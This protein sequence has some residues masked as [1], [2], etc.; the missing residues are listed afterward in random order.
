MTAPRAREQSDPPAPPDRRPPRRGGG[1][2]PSTYASSAG[3]G[4]RGLLRPARRTALAAA[5]LV[6]GSLALA[7]PAQAQSTTEI[8]SL[9]MTPGSISG[10]LVV[11]WD[12]V[13]GSLGSTIAE[14]TFSY[15]NKSYT[16]LLAQNV[17]QGGNN[18]LLIRVN[19]RFD[20]AALSDLILVVDSDEFPLADASIFTTTTGNDT[21]QWDNAGL[22][23]SAGTDVSLS[24]KAIT[25]R[26]TP[27]AFNVRGGGNKLWLFVNANLSNI[28]PPTSAFT[29]T[30][31]GSPVTIGSISL[32]TNLRT[33][34]LTDFSPL[35][36]AGQTVTLDYTDP[37]TGDDTNAIQDINGLD[38]ASFSNVVVNDSA[39]TLPKPTAAAVPADGATVAL[40]FSETLLIFQPAY[41]S[42]IRNAFTV[43]VDGTERQ[44]TDFAVSGAT[45]TLT[46]SDTIEGGQTVVVGYDRSAAGR[47][48]LGT[49]SK[50]LVA[51]FTTGE[52]S[53]PAVTNNSTA[54]PARLA[55]AAV[56]AAGTRLTL[57]FN[58]SLNAESSA[59][60]WFTVMADGAD[61][62]I[63]AFQGLSTASDSFTILFFSGSPIYKDEAVVVVYEKPAGSD[64][65]TDEANDVPVA[66]FTT[67]LDGVPAVANAATTVAP[68][69]PDTAASAS[70]VGTGGS[71]LVLA[72]DG[73]LATDNKPPASAFSITAGGV[74][75]GI[76]TVLLSSTMTEG[77]VSLAGLTPK[78]R[79]GETV[80]LT[81]TDPTSA[82]D[83]NALQGTTGTDV[84]SFTVT[85]TNAS[86]VTTG[87]PRP[88]TGLTATA[89][90]A[91]IVDLA[92]TAPA[93]DGDSAITGYKVEVSNT[94]SS[95]WTDLAAD[96]GDANAW[97]RHTGLS[98]G[99]T[100]YYRVSAINANGTSP[101][102][103]SA[104]A[105]TMTGALHAVPATIHGDEIWSAEL[106]VGRRANLA[107][108]DAENYDNT[109]GALSQATFDRGDGTMVTVSVV[110]Y[111]SRGR[112]FLW[113]LSTGLGA[114]FFNLHLGAATVE[115]D[116]PGNS[117]SLIVED[118]SNPGWS[119][120]DT[121]DVRLVEATAPAKPTGFTAT[122]AGNAQIDLA[123]TAPADDGGRA[124]S[125]YKIEVSDDGS[126]GSWDDLVADTASTDTAYS[127]TG[128]SA[129]DTRH[130]QVSA[131][132]AVGT[133]DAS[134]SDNATTQRTVPDPPEASAIADGTSKIV[135]SWSVPANDGGSAVTGYRLQVSPDGVSD[136]RN[137][138]NNTTD[139][140]YEHTGLSAGTT[141]HYRVYATNAQGTSQPSAVV[142][143]M[144]QGAGNTCTVNTAAGD[145][146]CGVVTVALHTEGGFD[147]AY[148]FVDTSVTTNTSD[149]GALSDE[150]FP[151]GP[152][153]YTIDVVTVGLD[154]VGGNLAFSLTSGLTAADKEKLVLHVGSR[155]FAFSDV[156]ANTDFTY[157]WHLS[158]L[159]WSSATSI[160]LR[161]RRVPAAPGAPTNLMAEAD[162]GTTIELSWTA[163]VDNGGSAITGYRIEVSDDGSTDWTDLEADT[164][165]A[166]TSYTHT[167][168]SPGDTR[169]YRVSAI[170][171]T[172]RSEASDSEDA[173]T[174]D[175]PTLSSATVN[176]V[177]TII[178]LRFSE[179]LDR[180]AGG[181][182]P[183]SA[184]SVSV[185][186]VSITVGDASIL[187]TSP[188]QV[189]LTSLGRTI[190][191]GQAVTVTYTD[192]T[193]GDDAAAIQDS[194]GDDTPSFTTGEDGVPAVVNNST[195]TPPVATPTNFRAMA[196]DAQVTLSWDEP[197]SDSGVT[198]H[199]Y[200]FR[201]D[202]D[203][204][205]WIEIDDSGPG[206]TNASGFTVTALENGTEYT[207]E[208]RAGGD[209][210]DSL[211]AD[212]VRVT[213]TGEAAPTIE[214]VA[215]TSTPR[216]TSAG[217][218]EPDTYGRGEP[219]E[220]S[221]TFSEAV[222]RTGDPQ[223]GFSLDGARVAD[224]ASGTGSETL[225]FVYSVRQDDVDDD[226]IWV[227][228]HS[229]GTRTLQLDSDDA[230]AAVEGGADA[231]LEH[232]R[233]NQL[234]G[235]KVDGSRVSEDV[236]EEPVRVTLHL[237]EAD[238]EVPE[239]GGA[240]TV[241]ARAS[242]GAGSAFTVT[243]SAQPVAPATAGD[244][245]LSTNPVLRFTANA[246]ASTGTV[247]IT[248]VDDDVPE[249]RDAVRV[250]GEVSGADIAD[251]EPVTL[252]IA[253]DDDLE[254][255]DVAVEGPAQVSE[256]DGAASV[257][258]TLTTQGTDRPASAAQLY[259]AVQ[260]GTATRGEDW[261]APSG[262]E[263]GTQSV[264]FATVPPG[265]F[266]ANGDGNWEARRS[267]TL[268]IV[269]DAEREASETVVFRVDTGSSRY[270]SAPHTI[271]IVDDDGPPGAPEKPA[272]AAV[273]GSFTSLEADWDEP[274]LDGA[275]A[276]TGYELQYREGA[277]GAWTAW[278]HEGASTTARLTGLAAETAYRV[279]V[280]ALNG[281][282]A[283]G[284]S[285]PSE[286]VLTGSYT[287]RGICN[288]TQRVEDRIMVR[289]KY[290]HSFK[291]GCAD[292]TEVELAKVEHLF[293]RRNP[294]IE[295]PVTVSLRRQDF[296]GLWN[297]VELDLA[298][299][300]LSSLPAGVFAGLTDLEVLN[301]N[302]NRL[303][304]LPA[305]V[306]AGLRS[307]EELRLQK[308][309]SL[310]S[311]PYD[312]LEAL[313]ALTLLRVDPEGRRTLQVAGG[314]ADADFEV[315]AGG[316]ATYRVRLMHRP[317]H[318]P[319]ERPAV[320]VRS[321]T[322]GVTVSPATL[323]F[324]K[325]NWFRSQAVR[326]HAVASLA[327]E[328]ARVEHDSTAVTLDRDPPA[329]TVRVLEPLRGRFVSPPGRH[330]G[331]KRVKVRVAFSEPVE[332]SPQN[333][334]AHGVRVN[335]GRVTSARR[336]G[337]GAP[338]GAA[339]R[340]PAR[341]SAPAA[342]GAPGGEVMWE[343]EIEP[344][345][346]ADLTVSLVAGRPC[347]AAG[348]I[349][350]A[351][352]R[353]LSEGISTTVRGPQTEPGPAPLTASFEGMPGEHDGESAFT[354]RVAFSADIG[355]SY[356][357]LREDAFAVSGGRVTGGRRVDD[358]R[359]LFEMT[360]EPDGEGDVTVTLPAGRECGISGAICTKGEN[361]RQL[362]NTPMATVA[363]PAVETGPA[364][365]TARFVDMPAEH[366]GKT[367]FK[368]RIAFSETIRM[369]GR[370]LRGDV[371]SVAGG[372]A[373]KAG[374]VNGRKDRWDLTVRPASL[375]DVT[376]TLSSG[377]AC[378]SPAAVCTADGKAL[379]HTLSTTVKGPVAVSVA[380]ARVR[381]A[382]GATL[383]FAVSLSRAA[384]GRV[385]V[386]YA[387][388]DGTATAGSDYTRA[389]GKL[390]FAPGETEKRVR[391]PVLDDVVDEG[392]ETFTL[393]LL[394]ASGAV[395]AD[396]EATGTIVNSDPLQKMW[397]SR[398]GRTVAGQVVDAVTGRLWGSSGGSRVTLGGQSIDL[399][400]QSAGTGEARRTLAGARP[401]SHLIECGQNPRIS[402]RRFCVRSPGAA[403]AA[404]D[405]EPP[406][407][408]GSWEAARAGSWE[409]PA[410]GHGSARTLTGRELLLG[411][412]FHLAAGG[413]EAGGPA[414][415]AWGRVTVG[416]FDAEAPADNGTMR[417]DGEV[418]TGLL[419]ADA[420]WERWLAGVALSVSEGKGTFDQPGVD[421]G[422]VESTLTSVNPYVRYRASDRL[423]AWG[424]LGYG[425]G[426]MTIRGNSPVRTDLMMR[427]GAAGARGVLL[428]AGET[429]GIDLALRGDAFL[430]QMDWEK[431]S[432]ETDTRA[433]ASRLRLV[434]EAG[435]S[436]T[437]GEGAVLAPALELGLRHDGGDA[438]TG[439]GVE[440][441]GRIRYTDAGSGL[442]VEAN[443][444]TLIA[445]E[446]SDYREWGAG[447]SVRLGPDASGRGLS[448]ALA[449]VWGT[450]SSG[451]DRLWSARDAAG[452]APG[453]EFEAERR[454]EGELGYGFGAFGGLG[455]VTPYAGLGLAEAGDR[456]WRAG[457]RWLLAPHLAM[458]LDG[459]RREPA[460]DDAPEHA[461]QFRFTLRW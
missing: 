103:A 429:G 374:A 148:G 168:L 241:T 138:V 163:P 306:F 458:S 387:T 348:A 211:A 216:L 287:I 279:R 265:S 2:S 322:P 388:A 108:Y 332:G 189:W 302:K 223:F 79:Q 294:S 180:S 369:S 158:G 201:T 249:P 344:D 194:D 407:G 141:R 126:T 64:G 129:G 26:P 262:P 140:S 427:L 181:T 76:G 93:D 104:N 54:G 352:G 242:R 153:N 391:V 49:G 271:S 234:S 351:D 256:S 235:H 107:G 39:V 187:G 317:A 116:N 215:V 436:F 452:L 346:E 430:V 199:D 421:S 106:T 226:G 183:V 191:Q 272:L 273:Q 46:M 380:D 51:N 179:N 41:S 213:P 368:L 18:R 238:G 128:L 37:S 411:S 3:G 149:T 21:A 415:A 270:Q 62:R 336:V 224:Y 307:L 416:G 393:R 379:S 154:A 333:V 71:G 97:Y 314:V 259:Y 38:A 56:D 286:A 156:T 117:T 350:T 225:V 274:A 150:T 151:V 358:R 318:G 196:G 143:D 57:T 139:T 435:R 434:L 243:V 102:S 366:D 152:N 338:D 1:S 285:P 408:L 423:T 339:A 6:L 75:I 372:R 248:P 170:N 218:T 382:A 400:A 431:V 406:A 96:T 321:V 356:R 182:P 109:L 263:S 378:D 202:G 134:A 112:R 45:A 359:D 461:A 119:H 43:T 446:D 32:Q 396:G 283:S 342:G 125:G 261:T 295:R 449:P 381:E 448:L 289:L 337:G 12:G 132:N 101:A 398:F 414:L 89:L 444:R 409:D 399:S 127:H 67:S 312:E 177:S 222:N 227:G 195:Q 25:G 269:N 122:A 299:I 441:G 137:L 277:G 385:S 433:D 440:V 376:V 60:D 53:V 69:E 155:S 438:E 267:F 320:T 454:L 83:T 439:T 133:S 301:L 456:T 371:V 172:G 232:D 230:I 422:T 418:T 264:L 98:D 254:P 204:E 58:K 111:G 419:G 334:G 229:S 78:V 113:F 410:A 245:T 147:L 36:G 403:R 84:H 341:S 257:T 305:G 255:F 327:G 142:S 35:I 70:K 275:A 209:D 22:S 310:R 315:A 61:V 8:W 210:G 343:F 28:L 171:A 290:V 63:N 198:H 420:A 208:L 52:N 413:G 120:G 31:A 82:D 252:S 15:N 86:T 203:Y 244:F 282:Q 135:V 68:P 130:Y 13:T 361:R 428:E 291:G 200:R 450:P 370:R 159:D 442:T 324:T 214:T 397:L 27:T 91:T 231:D 114:G 90:G 24:L 100:R 266:R 325:E 246:T 373:T 99:Y 42:A 392:E 394:N 250:S 73:P 363:G 34:D 309:P 9:N 228:N 72:F 331:E 319:T 217:G 459:T 178:A 169:H 258:V 308:N 390:R 59:R 74:A 23:W 220:F 212:E 110:T 443:A 173:T 124:V 304:S 281:S 105:T 354:F 237:S 33:L 425:T 326:V 347:E 353:A 404:N 340:S 384:S 16:F 383:D 85:L 402:P 77:A 92:W 349:C 164:G 375:A 136:W 190:Y 293:L 115:Y 144:T 193:T 453:G 313:P 44:T 19:R 123:W 95:G 29:L 451:V 81:Y 251:P 330:D 7:P 186:G 362:T 175:P 457:A 165:N 365:L 66:S 401:P 162:G 88:P 30:A 357:S 167:G 20:Q 460:N 5:G 364:G 10:T 323:R 247:T 292:V 184:F 236:P 367:A 445:H 329:L 50:R 188:K 328:T 412:S 80:E 253:N 447:G 284:W 55:S 160:T 355:I 303:R 233:L 17:V 424:L 335:A 360:V 197:A 240:V 118:Y 311:V 176:T 206:E 239:D 219:I 296:E 280:R 345:S 121:V 174:E 131:I 278:R 300:R 192:P 47:E 426:D 288:R 221:V 87:P 268:G 455:L 157:L 298:D 11:G 417:L 276:V 94:G 146:W 405:V 161:L 389:S 40:T 260:P 207:F 145:Y 395:V 65:F 166:D 377:A 386:S 316:A 205:G 297:L 432:N 48:A 437:L 185:D 4:L 14:R